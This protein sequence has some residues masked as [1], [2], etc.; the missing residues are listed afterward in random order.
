MG[1]NPT[2]NPPV[3]GFA[4]AALRKSTVAIRYAATASAPTRSSSVNNRRNQ[5]MSK[6]SRFRPCN[7]KQFDKN[8]ARVFGSKKL[9]VWQGAPPEEDSNGIQGNTG[10]GT[11]DSAD[12]GR[13]TDVPEKSG[14]EPD[15]QAAEPMES[16]PCGNCYPPPGEHPLDTN[17]WTW[18]GYREEYT[19][20]HGVGHGDH[21]HG[22]DGC[23]TRDD[24]PLKRKVR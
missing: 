10:D 16:P 18:S 23:C 3:C 14:R 4:A 19:C 12:S 24:F 15:S 22:C 11:R 9:N 6:G 5:P 7:K 2:R 21:V 17:Y 20:P 8:Y 13:A 1:T